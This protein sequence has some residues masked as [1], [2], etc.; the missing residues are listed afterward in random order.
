MLFHNRENKTK[1]NYLK[2]TFI[3]KN[4]IIIANTLILLS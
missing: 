4:K 1:D 3:N 2:K